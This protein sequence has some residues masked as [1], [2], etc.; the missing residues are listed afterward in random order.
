MIKRGGSRMYLHLL[1]DRFVKNAGQ[2]GGGALS[3]AE[4]HAALRIS[5]EHPVVKK[6]SILHTDSA[7]AYKKVGPMMWPE[8]GA[9]HQA[10]E[11]AEAYRTLE[12]THINVTHRRKVGQPIQFVAYRDIDLPDGSK[13]RVKGGTETIDG[14][15]AWLRGRVSRKAFNTGEVSTD[16][17]DALYRQ[18]RFSQW[19]FWHLS[20]DR[21]KLFAEY[22]QKF[23]S[24]ANFF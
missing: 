10:S 1:P 6:R 11:G 8:P 20:D 21:F 18:V 14:W 12:L 5:T 9:H 15:W 7:K 22:L 17:R 19:I 4:L 23:R 3:D 13:Y 2:G 24:E 16:K